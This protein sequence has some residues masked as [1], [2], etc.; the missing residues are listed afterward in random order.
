MHVLHK[1]ILRVSK[2]AEGTKQECALV[3]RNC[4][5]FYVITVIIVLREGHQARFELISKIF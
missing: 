5:L 2:M 3:E 1:L 4:V